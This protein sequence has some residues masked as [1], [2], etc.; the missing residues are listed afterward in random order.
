MQEVLEL[1]APAML[2]KSQVRPIEYAQD[3]MN[4]LRLAMA[5]PLDRGAMDDIGIITGCQIKPVVATPRSVMLV[6]VAR[7]KIAS[8]MDFSEKRKPQDGRNIHNVLNC[9]YPKIQNDLLS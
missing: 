8:G 3:N 4:I 9:S 1:V 5:D 7:L 6:L 2:K